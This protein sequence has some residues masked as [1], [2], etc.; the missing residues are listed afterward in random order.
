MRSRA[1]R[2]QSFEAIKANLL[3]AGVS[4][5]KAA[6]THEEMF[7]TSLE[8]IAEAM[9]LNLDDRPQLNQVLDGSEVNLI[10]EGLLLQRQEA[11]TKGDFDAY[12]KAEEKQQQLEEFEA[13]RLERQARI[14]EAKV[15]IQTA[16]RQ[17][18]SS[19]S[20]IEPEQHSQPPSSGW[21]A[22]SLKAKYKTL[23]AVQDAFGI[24]AKSW[25]AAVDQ[26]N[27]QNLQSP[28]P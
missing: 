21:T 4:V 2:N 1:E 10:Y 14:L 5:V 7:N 13:I 15:R 16:Q 25:K 27:R 23:K 22:D 18:A 12:I 3:T 6:K 28:V 17:L 11:E 19:A 9:E 20:A 24:V 8:T 26:I